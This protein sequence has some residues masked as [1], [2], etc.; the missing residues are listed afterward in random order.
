MVVSLIKIHKRLFFLNL[1]TYA[2]IDFRG[3]KVRQYEINGNFYELISDDNC[4][5]LENVSEY[6]TD[7][8]N[9]FDYIF[10]D[11]VGDRVRLKG[12]YDND[13][14]NSKKY[15]RINFLEYYKKEYC[16]Y[17][18]KTFLLKKLRKK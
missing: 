3:D 6:V 2:I 8:F 1:N 12:F 5:S 4:F 15:N 18:A 7:Y 11:F 9:D 13:Y 17:G 14:K 10:G 16:N